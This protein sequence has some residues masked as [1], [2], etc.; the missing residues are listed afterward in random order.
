MTGERLGDVTVSNLNGKK[1][2]LGITGSIAA[3][4]CVDLARE[5]RKHGAEVIAVMTEEAMRI[6]HPNAMEFATGNPVITELTGKIEHVSLLGLNG[7]ADMLLIAPSTANTLSKIA[8]GIDDTPVTTMATTAIGSGIP[9]SIAPAMHEGMFNHPKIKE[10]IRSLEMLGIQIIPP[11]VKEGKAKLA[12]T[13]TIVCYLERIFTGKELKGKKV[14]ITSG[15]SIERI[16]PIRFITNR[17][18][19]IMGTELALECWRR[20]A[21]VTVIQAFEGAYPFINYIRAEDVRT[22][23]D[24]VMKE[25]DKGYDLFISAAAISDFTV[26]AANTKIKTN[27]NVSITLKEAPKVIREVR[28]AFDIHIIGFKAETG[29]NDE[30]LIKI[31]KEKLQCD[32]LQMVVANDVL[33]KGMGTKDDRVVIVTERKE[34]W[35]EGEKS[36]IAR[37]ILDRYAEEFL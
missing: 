27:R 6:I 16:D 31:A 2:V 22:I 18:A 14:L 17:S 1:I 5:L 32:S 15:P 23:L 30:E 11:E 26:D 35:I 28:K 29:V 20:G 34:E 9:V 19:G 12:S 24:T 4:R 10:H 3:V 21:D 33:E 37:R 25:L 8:C 13:N 36:L 7:E